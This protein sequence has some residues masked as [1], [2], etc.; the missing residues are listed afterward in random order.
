LLVR[1]L[2]SARDG[3]EALNQCHSKVS[4]KDWPQQDQDT[5][6]CLARLVDH[7]GMDV[8]FASGA[9]EEKKQA[10]VKGDLP[11][12]RE[13]AERFYREAGPILDDLS[14]VGLPA[15]THHLLETLQVFVP[16][17]HRGVF[18]RIGRVVRGG[19]KGGYQYESLAANLI[20]E[21]VERYLADYRGLLREDAECRRT[22]IEILN[23]FVQ[24][25]WPS[26]RRLTYR[27]EEIF[28]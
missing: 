8:Y 16:L 21:L 27:L 28:R 23:V 7:V 9:H 12:T 5:A 10:Q 26:A 2:R 14:D 25:G 13:R 19:E 20:V 3:L 22:L 24:A 4:F 15:V 17:D 1:V 18:L 6:K 11:Q